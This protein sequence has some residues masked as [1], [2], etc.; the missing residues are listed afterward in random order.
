M[1]VLLGGLLKAHDTKG[2]AE[3]PVK[4]SWVYTDALRSAAMDGILMQF[5][6]THPF[7]PLQALRATIK[8]AQEA[9][10]KLESVVTDLFAA[11]WQ[12]GHDLST[13]KTVAGVLAN[14]A[15]PFSEEACNSQEIKDTLRANTEAAVK[16]GAF[17]VPSYGLADGTVL[18]GHD[19]LEH[20]E[21]ILSNGD[22]VDRELLAEALTTPWGFNP[23]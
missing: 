6:P 9:P 8:T 2:P 11:A 17:G 7:M 10:D 21:Y 15:L 18:W 13:W 19:R 1:P 4:R 23:K 16:A 14:H 12:A 20:L 3:T 22:P 5:P